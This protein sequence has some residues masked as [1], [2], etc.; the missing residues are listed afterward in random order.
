MNENE[1]RNIT[2]RILPYYIATVASF[3]VV[4]QHVTFG[5]RAK[6]RAQG[7]EARMRAPAVIRL[8]FVNVLASVPI[9]SQLGAGHIITATPVRS[10]RVEAL[11]LTRTMPVP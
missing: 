8:T 2:Q 5:T 1:L 4:A 6:N 10:V 11:A 9:V 3:P 7:V